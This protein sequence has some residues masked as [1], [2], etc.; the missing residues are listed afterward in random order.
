MAIRKLTRHGILFH[1]FHSSKLFYKSPGSLNKDQFYKFIK[2]NIKKIKN[3]EEFL[4][5]E[6][7]KDFM[8]LTFDD[9]LK[10]QYKIALDILENFK[11][12]GFFF[13]FSGSLGNEHLS[14]ENIRY[15][16]YKFFHNRDDFY[17]FFFKTY[18][19]CF[20]EKLVFDD[21]KSKKLIK[22]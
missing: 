7:N 2:N 10:S 14:V 15:F 20:S 19:E 13:I 6:S 8:T 4:N 11:L 22:L 18:E 21:S 3:P 12:K 16:S 5:S 17:N 1:Q 9:G